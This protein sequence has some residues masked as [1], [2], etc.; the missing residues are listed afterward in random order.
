MNTRTPSIPYM[1]PRSMR[2][3]IRMDC[4]QLEQISTELS[5]FFESRNITYKNTPRIAQT[6]EVVK[7]RTSE[8]QYELQFVC[9]SNRP[10]VIT[11]RLYRHT[12]RF[13]HDLGRRQVVLTLEL[14]KGDEWRTPIM[15][16]VDD[17]MI[18][19]SSNIRAP[20]ARFVATLDEDKPTSAHYASCFVIA[21]AQPDVPNG[22]MILTNRKGNVEKHVPFTKLSSMQTNPGHLANGDMY[23]VQF[24]GGEFI[25]MN[26]VR[27]EQNFVFPGT[28]GPM[29]FERERHHTILGSSGTPH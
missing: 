3:I 10:N 16:L 22:C 5:N 8:T 20:K 17:Y 29:F 21:R 28:V 13:S 25:I 27:F 26:A 9:P 23:Y 1:V 18:P 4:Q 15:Q 14:H 6:A 19:N 24:F 11:V 12:D 7:I 2:T